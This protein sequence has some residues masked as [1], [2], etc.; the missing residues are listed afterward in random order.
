MKIHS[1]KVNG[2]GDFNEE[3]S[4]PELGDASTIA[5]T[6]LNGV[7][8][9]TFLECI[10]ALLDGDMPS[11]G[12]VAA[13]AKAKNSYIEGVLETDRIYRLRRTINATLKKPKIEAYIWSENGT[14]IGGSDGKQTTFAAE[15]SKVFPSRA[16][17]LSSGFAS[18][19]RVGQFL[20]ISKAERKALFADL[21]GLEHLQKLSQA[22]ADRAKTAEA[23]LT[24]L[25]AKVAAFEEQASGLETLKEQINAK[26]T[27]AANHQDKREKA[28]NEA[29]LVR[30]KLDK[31]REKAA[32]LDQSVTEANADLREAKQNH[33]RVSEHLERTKKDIVR[34][35]SEQ[36][37]LRTKIAKKDKLEAIVS[38]ADDNRLPQV[39]D[40][41]SKI[42]KAIDAHHD[43]E[44]GWRS[45]RD[46]AEKTLQSCRDAYTKALDKAKNDVKLARQ[47]CETTTK[48]AA[49][50][51]KVPC[52]GDGEYA[53]CPLIKTATDAAK[54]LDDMQKDLAKAEDKVVKA[55]ANTAAGLKAKSALEAVGDAPTPPDISKLDPLEREA[56]E[57]RLR[58][59]E[60]ADARARLKSLADAEQALKRLETE[61]EELSTKQTTDTDA[62]ATKASVVAAA[63]GKLLGA[64]DKCHDHGKTKPQP[65]DES[66]ID[67]LRRQETELVADLARL[68]TQV[69]DATAAAEKVEQ[70][71]V[72]IQTVTGDVDDWRHLQKAFGREGIQSLEVD[73]AGPEVSSLINDL[74]S[75]CYGSRFV[76]KLETTVP[77][78]DGKGSKEIFDLHVLDTEKGWEGSASS[79]SGGEK[80]IVA[81]ALGLAIAIYNARQSSIPILDL[82]RDECSGSLD[83]EKAPLYVTML[84]KAV[85]VGGFHRIF[86]VTHQRELWNLADVQL[87]VI[88]GQCRVVEAA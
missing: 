60:I 10:L 74:L 32:K 76:T 14:P 62:L 88:D 61:K 28:E 29:V 43:V 67:E 41:I 16:V 55:R 69:T 34:V 17:Y 26:R 42:R 47:R 24:E 30:E 35:A 37:V 49:G 65:V 86:F 80:V 54:V 39:D 9:S 82:I 5:V 23:R 3:I 53:A 19:G 81:E 11:R 64:Q 72:E 73:A 50:L 51:N 18:Q 87:K 48:T 77:L 83:H 38:S 12:P 2:I 33:E 6:G 15:V 70:S 71:R 79:L 36:G 57:L 56:R 68:E 46:A 22:S 78:V 27:E 31:W 44:R 1:L 25:R 7:G 75:S 66:T 20:E 85:E 40:E 4:L 59:A 63:E 13:L 8:K 58:Q 45:R 21:I 52:H 84:R